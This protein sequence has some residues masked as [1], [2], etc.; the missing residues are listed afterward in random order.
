M[1]LTV[2]ESVNNLSY[3]L[4][5]RVWSGWYPCIITIWMGSWQMK[6]VWGKLFKQLHLSHTWWKRR[7]SM[8]L[9]SSLCLCRKYLKHL[10]HVSVLRRINFP[11]HEDAIECWQLWFWWVGQFACCC[12][13]LLSE[14]SWSLRMKNWHLN[15]DQDIFSLV[16]SES[17]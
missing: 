11:L 7:E 15:Q 9:I 6:W 17:I 14:N 3:L 2:A 1:M 10:L 8:D 13:K 5:F 4:L 16:W 12:I